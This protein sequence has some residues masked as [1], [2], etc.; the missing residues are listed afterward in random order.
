MM[1]LRM[2]LRVPEM[3]ERIT[4]IAQS[5]AFSSLRRKGTM[6]GNDRFHQCEA[7]IAPEQPDEE[8]RERRR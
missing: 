3:V 6:L 4:A 1:G 8:H 7:E 5:G 2:K